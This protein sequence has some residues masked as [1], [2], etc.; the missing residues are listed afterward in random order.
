METPPG[1]AQVGRGVT[2]SRQLPQALPLGPPLYPKQLDRIG[3]YPLQPRVGARPTMDQREELYRQTHDG[4]RPSPRQ[5]GGLPSPRAPRPIT[6]VLSPTPPLSFLRST[7]R[8][9]RLVGVL[10]KDRVRCPR[11]PSRRVH[12]LV[13]KASASLRKDSGAARGAAPAVSSALLAAISARAD[14]GAAGSGRRWA[15]FP[16]RLP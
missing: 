5:G 4:G 7:L 3:F 9:Q 12:S 14:R 15:S 10:G 6:A 1:A 8:P 2:R 13:K 11:A 16:C